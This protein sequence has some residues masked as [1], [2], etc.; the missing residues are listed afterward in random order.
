MLRTFPGF[1]ILSNLPLLISTLFIPV[2]EMF[3]RQKRKGS[4]KVFAV[5]AEMTRIHAANFTGP[6]TVS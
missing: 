4:I 5:R 3:E 1:L 6:G 2:F